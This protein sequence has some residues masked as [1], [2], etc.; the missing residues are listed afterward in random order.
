MLITDIKDQFTSLIERVR[1]TWQP[2]LE[3]K[4]IVKEQEL[5]MEDYLSKARH[6]WIEAQNYFDNVSEPELVD[7]ASYLLRA[8]ESKYTYLLKKY[9][10]N[11]MNDQLHTQ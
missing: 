2:I 5:E 3:E 9:K 4:G 11:R 8:A 1:D 6:E 7:H 10:E